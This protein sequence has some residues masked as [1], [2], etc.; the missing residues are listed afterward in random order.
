MWRALLC[1]HHPRLRP[2]RLRC[3]CHGNP[4][5]QRR[6]RSPFP[7]TD[8]AGPALARWTTQSSRWLLLRQL[9]VIFSRSPPH[10]LVV[11]SDS[12]RI[13]HHSSAEFTVKSSCLGHRVLPFMLLSRCHA[14]PPETSSPVSGRC[15]SSSIESLHGI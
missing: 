2:W 15:K 8:L 7:S 12:E 5:D 3:P 6:R 11:A 10:I 13:L 4:P 1:P 9:A 14:K